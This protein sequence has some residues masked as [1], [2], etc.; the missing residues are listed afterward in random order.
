MRQKRV[1]PVEYLPTAADYIAKAACPV[2][3]MVLVGSLALFV[4]E[5]T[6]SGP[7]ELRLKWLI[8]WCV[9]AIVGIS[10]IAIEKSPAYAGMYALAL[11]L[12]GYLFVTRFFEIPLVGWFILAVI[13]WCT[14]KLVYDCTLIDDKDDASGEGL[15]GVAGIDETGGPEV[16]AAAASTKNKQKLPLWKRVFTNARAR[17]EQ[18]HAPGLWVLYFSLAAL[19]VFGFGQPLMT[20]YGTDGF[21]MFL[22]LVYLVAAIGLLL[23]T[24][25]LGLRRYLRQRRL[26][27]PGAMATRWIMTG[28][29]ILMLVLLVSLFLPRPL[30]FCRDS[31][32]PRTSGSEGP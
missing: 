14:N 31:H 20:R 25:F 3:I 12:V 24:S 22:M 6:Y 17:N 27:M 23:L 16:G 32:S 30:R 26:K 28:A 21:G 4:Q 11:G 10:R 29:S 8:F 5:A 7:H 18:P 15:L 2:L 13:W 9:L 1:N 19:P